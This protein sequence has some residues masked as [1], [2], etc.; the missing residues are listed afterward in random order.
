MDKVLRAITLSGALFAIACL[1]SVNGVPVNGSNLTG[2]RRECVQDT[3]CAIDKLKTALNM[4]PNVELQPCLS[5]SSMP[6][7]VTELSYVYLLY[8][9][10]VCVLHTEWVL[11]CSRKQCRPVHSDQHC[12]LICSLHCDRRNL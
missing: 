3:V 12:T 1:T 4:L 11:M 10:V 6:F 9:L 5:V 7:K 2:T 8:C